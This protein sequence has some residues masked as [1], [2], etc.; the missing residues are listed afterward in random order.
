MESSTLEP[1][2]GSRSRRYSTKIVAKRAEVVGFAKKEL[3][4][5][6]KRKSQR[7]YCCCSEKKGGDKCTVHV[8]QRSKTNFLPHPHCYP[9]H[10]G[11]PPVKTN[12]RYLSAEFNFTSG[13]FYKT[14]E[15]GYNQLNKM[16]T[17]QHSTPLKTEVHSYFP[18]RRAHV[19]ISSLTMDLLKI[20]SGFIDHFTLLL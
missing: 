14:R 10:S 19:S 20:Q 8:K 17:P 6:Y 9:S 2:S 15:H 11:Y 12:I 4:T 18:T 1:I 5:I 7:S 13:M 16:R 3:A